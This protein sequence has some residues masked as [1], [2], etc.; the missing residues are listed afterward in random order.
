MEAFEALLK[1][2]VE[3]P[4]AC[5]LAVALI[6]LAFL[7]KAREAD[8]TAKEAQI[9]KLNDDHKATIEKVIPVAEKLADGVNTLERLMEKVG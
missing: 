5:M 4:T 2:I 6:A 9:Q 1:G 3:H 8:R 7:Y